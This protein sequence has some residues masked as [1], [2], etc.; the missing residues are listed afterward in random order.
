MKEM[1]L[2]LRCIER[3]RWDGAIDAVRRGV[4]CVALARLNLSCVPDIA[5]LI[6]LSSR[7]QER[8][9]RGAERRPTDL[10]NLF[11]LFT[12]ALPPSL[13]YFWHIDS[14]H[15]DSNFTIEG[16]TNDCECVTI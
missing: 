7:S 14:L 1:T 15:F 6:S 16:N 10:L 12:D 4:E 3:D 2:G 5:R 8:E 11:R 13:G 9:H